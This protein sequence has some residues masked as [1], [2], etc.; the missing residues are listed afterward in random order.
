M[1]ANWCLLLRV[2]FCDIL[3]FIRRGLIVSSRMK[4]PVFR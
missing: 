3:M 1:V 2:G 4:E